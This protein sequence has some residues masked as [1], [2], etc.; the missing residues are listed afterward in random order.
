[1]KLPLSIACNGIVPHNVEKYS[2]AGSHGDFGKEEQAA[3]LRGLATAE[4][5]RGL[6]DGRSYYASDKVLSF[7]AA[8]IN[9]SLYFVEASHVTLMKVLYNGMVR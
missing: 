8:F 4:G 5:V 2:V 3:Q 1:M 9:K 6:T 7:V